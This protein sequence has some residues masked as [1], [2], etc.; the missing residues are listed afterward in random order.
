MRVLAPGGLLVISMENCQKLIV[1]FRHALGQKHVHQGHLEFFGLTETKKMLEPD[2]QILDSCT[3]GFLFGMHAVTKRIP[4][5]MGPL[6][7]ANRAANRFFGLLAPGGGHI[8]FISAIREGTLPAR[9]FSAPFRCPQ[10]KRDLAF[11][12][13]P[14]GCGLKLP[15][16]PEGFFDAIE[17]NPELKAALESK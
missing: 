8:F 11:G 9:P 4:L 12:T 10:C 1:R 2:F 7:L 3:I 14:C 6:R 5:P 17:F 15:Y 13:T 16:A